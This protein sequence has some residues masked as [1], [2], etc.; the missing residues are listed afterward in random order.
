MKH[1]KKLLVFT[2]MIGFVASLT[3]CTSSKPYYKKGKKKRKKGCNCPSFSADAMHQ[4][5]S[6]E[7][8]ILIEY[9]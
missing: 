8:A 3:S 2:L 1:I 5:I 7:K 4:T 9:T 6:W